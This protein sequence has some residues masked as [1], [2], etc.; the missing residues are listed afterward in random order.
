LSRG[1]AKDRARE[2]V[3]IEDMLRQQGVDF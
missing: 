3:I 2:A 1:A